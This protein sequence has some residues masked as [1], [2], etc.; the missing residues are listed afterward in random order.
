MSVGLALL[1]CILKE[2]KDLSV[3]RES[4]ITGDSFQKDEKIVYDFI[5]SHY[6]K[7]GVV[8]KLGTVEEETQ[9]KIPKFPDEPIGFW[10]EG[11]KRRIQGELVSKA[12]KELQSLAV[13]GEMVD[14]SN[15]ARN[16][17]FD[18]EKHDQNERVITLARV[19]Q[20]V[21]DAHDLRQRKGVISGVPFGIDYLDKISDGAQPGD[22]VALVGRPG[23]GKTYLLLAMANY[24]YEGNDIPL[25][26]TTE[27]STFQCARRLVA[28]RTG[29]S[30]TLIRLGRMSFWGRRKVYD[31]I[32]VIMEEEGRPFHLMQGTFST[33]IED[34][35]LRVK[36][37]RP[38]S[39]YVDGAYLLRSKNK[40][41]AKWE[42]V[43][44]TAEFL[45][46]VASEFGIP[47]IS[48]YQFNRKG[49]GLGNIGYSDAVGQLASIVIGIEEDEESS[50]TKW[51]AQQT[52][53]ITLY[54]G[55]EGERGQIRIVYDM[56]HMKIRQ[57][58]I[59]SGFDEESNEET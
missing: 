1:R 59:V 39:L 2:R 52:K 36:E 28:L 22:A 27:M 45:K 38:T 19:V 24:A 48:T 30:A 13:S 9:I 51:G 46:L 4:G 7:H 50:Q 12:I 6:F 21:L 43:S 40:N 37:L 16:L 47:V 3:L 57:Q 54:K 35:F 58:E 31:D 33:T 14:A 23:V 56:E 44:E 8:P 29:V 26:V 18:L 32:T 11:V 41:Q 17:V 20:S 25:V 15:V 5:E 10:I 34:I 49:P 53:L 42:R 55:R